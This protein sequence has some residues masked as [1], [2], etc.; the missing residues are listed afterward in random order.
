MF[1]AGFEIAA[2]VPLVRAALAILC[3]GVA[4]KLMDDF[5]DFRY[6]A[7]YGIP[8]P[9]VRLGEATLPYAMAALALGAAMNATLALCLFS[10]AYAIGMVQDLGRPLPS[11]LLGWQEGL[12]AVGIGALCLDPFVQLWALVVMAFVQ[13]VDDL[14][15]LKSDAMAGSPNLA[16]RFGVGEVRLAALGLLALAAALRPFDTAAVVVAVACVEAAMWRLAFRSRTSGAVERL[17]R[18]AAVYDWEP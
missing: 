5:L 7:Q 13:A 14:F 3:T 4:V 17:R 6:D 18:T 16:R 1:G 11:G 15:D 8:S 12:L 9:A 10:S 2:V